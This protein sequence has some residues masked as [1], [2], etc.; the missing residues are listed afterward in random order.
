MSYKI[1]KPGAREWLIN[2]NIVVEL[3]RRSLTSWL[4]ENTNSYDSRFKYTTEEKIIE[5][6]LNNGFTPLIGCYGNKKYSEKDAKPFY[7]VNDT[8]SW[9]LF[10]GVS[11]DTTFPGNCLSSFAVNYDK[12][13]GTFTAYHH[14]GP[15]YCKR[16]GIYD[17]I[18]DVTDLTKDYIP[19]KIIDRGEA[20][21]WVIDFDK[22]NICN[23]SNNYCLSKEIHISPA[24]LEQ[25]IFE[26]RV[27]NIINNVSKYIIE[28]TDGCYRNVKGLRDEPKSYITVIPNVVD[29]YGFVVD[30]EQ[31]GIDKTEGIGFALIFEFIDNN[32]VNV[33][34]YEK[35]TKY[36]I[37]SCT[38]SINIRRNFNIGESIADQ[39]LSIVKTLGVYFADP[40][41]INNDDCGCKDETKEG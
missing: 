9:F 5:H 7:E 31:G 23:I 32:S 21:N 30:T 39:I 4:K 13:K 16:I 37:K 15:K 38:E 3:K 8:I 14:D 24:Y 17:D 28:T 22:L 1:Q 12:N 25:S 2:D 35:R 33:S 36:A 26:E 27:G 18:Y 6:F 11:D 34:L 41:E 19:V 29:T 40:N 20:K 10:D